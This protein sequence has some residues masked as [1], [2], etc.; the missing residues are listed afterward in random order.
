MVGMSVQLVPGGNGQQDKYK[1]YLLVLQLGEH[2][3]SANKDVMKMQLEEDEDLP[4]WLTHIRA[5]CGSTTTP[6]YRYH[7]CWLGC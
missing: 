6:T 5:Q 1:Y 4:R 7:G 2:A 3:A